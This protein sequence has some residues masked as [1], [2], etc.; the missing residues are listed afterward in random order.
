MHW[1]VQ[2]NA[3][4]HRKQAKQKAQIPLNFHTNLQTFLQ[5]FTSLG[6]EEESSTQQQ[7][8]LINWCKNGVDQQE[9]D[10]YNCTC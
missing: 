1:L 2:G 6:E 10:N 5:S 7:K 9:C 3:S 4:S 8:S